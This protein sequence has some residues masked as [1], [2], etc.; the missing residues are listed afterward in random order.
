[1]HYQTLVLKIFL[2]FNK[3]IFHV[4]FRATLKTV[5]TFVLWT[6][7]SGLFAS[8][9]CT[10][11]IAYFAKKFLPEDLEDIRFHVVVF[12]F[13]NLWLANCNKFCDRLPNN[14]DYVHFSFRFCICFLRSC[15]GKC[16]RYIIFWFCRAVSLQPKS[17]RFI[18]IWI[19]KSFDKMFMQ[20]NDYPHTLGNIH[21]QKCFLSF[22]YHF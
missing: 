19:H 7:Q 15:S 18:P 1:M 6:T 21:S 22:A 8:T 14:D 11:C 2:F 16:F 17:F 3:T 20:T 4:P 5:N 10:I 9:F 12:R 13:I